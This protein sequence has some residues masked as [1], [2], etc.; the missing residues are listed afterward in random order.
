[1]V[2]IYQYVLD[3]AAN[4]LFKNNKYSVHSNKF[5]NSDLTIKKI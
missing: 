3:V 2:K 1:M 5:I 4:E